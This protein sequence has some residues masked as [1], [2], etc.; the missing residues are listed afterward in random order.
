MRT[1]LISGYICFFLLIGCNNVRDESTYHGVEHSTKH[2]LQEQTNTICES[3]DDCLESMRRCLLKKNY[4]KALEYLLKME[5]HCHERDIGGDAIMKCYVNF[6]L[7]KWQEVS[8]DLEYLAE[9]IPS[10]KLFWFASIFEMR[11]KNYRKVI[12]YL[13]KIELSDTELTYPRYVGLLYTKHMQKA[14][15]LLM[16]NEYE[17]GKEEYQRFLDF[18]KHHEDT[19]CLDLSTSYIDMMDRAIASPDEYAIVISDQPLPD[20]VPSAE[21]GKVSVIIQY[22]LELISK[23]DNTVVAT[24]TVKL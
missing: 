12:E 13:D 2:K 17:T 8:K 10:P 11:M 7:D 22:H 16:L 24:Y 20:P 14:T 9:L 3:Y 1:I 21:P 5:N 4:N 6:M 18:A 23:K 19:I 15:A